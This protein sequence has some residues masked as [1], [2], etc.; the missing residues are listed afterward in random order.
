MADVALRTVPERP[1][2]G[3]P[4]E[5]TFTLADGAG[6]P[7]RG[8]TTH[9]GRKLHVLIVSEDMEVFGHVHPQDFEDPVEDGEATVFFT[10]PR[11]GRYLAAV[12][13]VTDAGAQAAQF[14][15]DVAGPEEPAAVAG[16][17]AAA[18]MRLVEL[19][20]GDRYT[21]PV[22]MGRA[23]EED[24]YAVSLHKPDLI[25]AGAELSLVYRF[26][27]DGATLT[28]L[29]PYLDAPLHLAVVKDDLSQFRH[30][31]GTVPGEEH[32][33]HGAH[34]SG[35]GDHA[36]GAYQGSSAFGPELRATLSFPEPGTYYLFGQTAH[37]DRLLITRFAV[38]V[39]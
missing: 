31:H 11:A 34:G 22:V 38:E 19:A 29:R 12:D 33:G 26:T 15:L 17:G 27:K 25:E 3:E 32:A 18:S 13:F 39:R 24:G 4:T 30:E 36:A 6:Q 37:R 2:A 5:L 20:E 7:I 14:L 21:D 28:D 8:L 10:F 9:H 16:K 23:D 35:H 1:R